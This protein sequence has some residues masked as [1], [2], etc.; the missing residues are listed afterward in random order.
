MKSY[1]IIS[2]LLP[3]ALLGAGCE[4]SSQVQTPSPVTTTA[5][6]LNQNAQKAIEKIKADNAANFALKIKCAP[7]IANKQKE[8]DAEQVDWSSSFSISH[9]FINGCYSPTFNTCVAIYD[10]FTRENHVTQK[11]TVVVEDLLSSSDVLRQDMPISDKAG[12]K[13]MFN[14]ILNRVNC[15]L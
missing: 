1:L 14:D 7:S 9:S 2:V 10:E 13:N 8:I 6:G 4:S 5:A 3:L 11:D 12:T 15:V